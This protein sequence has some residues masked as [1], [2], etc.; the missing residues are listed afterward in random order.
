MKVKCICTGIYGGINLRDKPS[1][2]S[3]IIGSIKKDMI[4]DVQKENS[5]WFS[6]LD[7]SGYVASS[8]TDSKGTIKWEL[9]KKEKIP[10]TVRNIVWT[11]HIGSIKNGK[12]WCCKIEDISTANFECGHII[13]EKNGGKITID[14]L[15]PI[16]GH[17][18]KSIGTTNM[19]DFKK[20]YGIE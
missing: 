13:S 18:N 14:N 8:L 10:A 1:L 3:N 12:C 7:G 20:K 16:C 19:E 6:L 9:V 11:N 5:G 17:C 15:R 4:I 2:D